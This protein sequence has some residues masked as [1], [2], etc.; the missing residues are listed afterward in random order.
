MFWPRRPARS[1]SIVRRVAPCQCFVSDAK[2]SAGRGYLR[3]RRRCPKMKLAGTNVLLTGAS[4]GLG[5]ALARALAA[6]G[7]KLVLV[8]RGEEKL[9]AVVDELRKGGADAHAV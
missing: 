6:K 4:M 8:A 9:R 2:E 5:E 3:D 1:C 7:A